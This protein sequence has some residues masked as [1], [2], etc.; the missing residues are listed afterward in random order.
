MS[1]GT[2]VRI[3]GA[4]VLSWVYL[5]FVFIVILERLDLGTCSYLHPLM[6]IGLTMSVKLRSLCLRCLLIALVP[7][8]NSLTVMLGRM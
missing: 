4:M 2:C 7:F 6:P 8:A 5:E 1:R 3:L